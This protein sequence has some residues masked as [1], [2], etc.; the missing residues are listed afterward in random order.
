MHMALF[1]VNVPLPDSQGNDI[2]KPVRR[3]F[4][5]ENQQIRVASIVEEL[6]GRSEPEYRLDVLLSLS[7]G[8]GS[9]DEDVLLLV[10]SRGIAC[11]ACSSRPRF[12]SA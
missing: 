10:Q 2:T 9:D 11:I 1:E 4:R 6:V 8:G 3:V 12:P 5:S 7:Q